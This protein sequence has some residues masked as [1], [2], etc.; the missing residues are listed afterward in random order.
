MTPSAQPMFERVALIGI[1]L[2]GS[3]LTHATR[4]RG[5]APATPAHRSRGPRHPASAD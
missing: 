1:A 3:S 4:R 5:L 2:I